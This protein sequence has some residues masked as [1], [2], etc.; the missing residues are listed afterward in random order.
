[1][2]MLDTK[3]LPDRYRYLLRLSRSGWAW[4]FLRRNAAYR[5][6]TTAAAALPPDRQAAF[7][8]PWGLH[9]RGTS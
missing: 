3:R 8:A 4:E 7:A 9:F 6:A 1:M 5:A 2:R